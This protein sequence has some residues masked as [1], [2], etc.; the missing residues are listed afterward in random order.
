MGKSYQHRQHRKGESHGGGHSQMQAPT[1]RSELIEK[2][3]GSDGTWLCLIAAACALVSSFQNFE[4]FLSDGDGD[5]FTNKE[6]SEVVTGT[7]EAAMSCLYIILTL[8]ESVSESV[9]NLLPTR[10]ALASWKSWVTS[11]PH[12]RI[13]IDTAILVV[14]SYLILLDINLSFLWL[15]I[16]PLMAIVFIR[17]LYIKFSR[18]KDT[19]ESSNTAEKTNRK[20]MELKIIV[21]VTLG[22]LFVM[23]QLPDHVAEGFA[24]SQFLLF[25]S[26]TVAALTR[27]TMKLPDGATLPGIEPA[28]EMLDKSLLVLLLVTAHTVAAEWLGEDVVLVCLPEVIPVLL[29][30]SLH[31]DRK[32]GSSSIISVDKMKPRQKSLVFLGAILVLVAVFF[33]YLAISMD[34]SG[35]SS[36]CTTFLVSYGVSGILT[37]FL[38]F[39]LSSWPRHKVTAAGRDGASG[40]L[41]VWACSLLIAAAASLLLRCLQ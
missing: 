4:V 11:R 40:M 28:S 24:I 23:D 6:I 36:C 18:G 34:E 16:F 39:M 15:A 38:G 2:L 9:S 7:M 22:A 19:S 32:P 13:F 10:A 26:T 5:G 25:L 20:T 35:L 37:S 31:V 14:L 33:T 29:W 12:V 1:P 41:K 8:H 30:F 3:G 27:M 21:M 17:A